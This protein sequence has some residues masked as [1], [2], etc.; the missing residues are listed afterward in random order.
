MDSIIS[1]PKIKKYFWKSRFL[2]E[3][4][5]FFMIVTIFICFQFSS[6]FINFWNLSNLHPQK[7]WFNVDFFHENF[8]LSWTK[9]DLWILSWVFQKSKNTFGKVGFGVK[10]TVFS[11][12]SPFFFVFNSDQTSSNFGI[13]PRYTPKSYGLTLIFF[14]KISFQAKL[15][16]IYGF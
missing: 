16:L 10:I 6:K 9:P 15:N 5:C 14:M 1:F 3:N 11:W 4:Y 2:V 12:F 7:L 8:I 13:C